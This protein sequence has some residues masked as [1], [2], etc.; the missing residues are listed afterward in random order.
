MGTRGSK[1]YTKEFRQ[2]SAR[3]AVESDKAIAATARDLSIND[4]TPS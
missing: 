3:M 2:S 4:E 1:Q